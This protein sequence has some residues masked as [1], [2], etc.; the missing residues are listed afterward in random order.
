MI[1]I[2][3]TDSLASIREEEGL[4]KIGNKIIKING[5]SSNKSREKHR[6][7]RRMLI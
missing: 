2:E 3:C 1:I 4:N 6:N 7:K 5:L